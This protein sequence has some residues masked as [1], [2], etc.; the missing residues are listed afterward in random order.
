MHKRLTLIVTIVAAQGIALYAGP[1][2][3]AGKAKA[4]SKAESTQGEKRVL[5]ENP[6][7]LE[8]R[9]LYYGA[10]GKED[11]PAADAVFTFEKEDMNGTNPKYVVRDD[12]GTKWKV[13]LGD[14][15]KPEPVAA[16]LV[17]AVG[18]SADEDYFMPTIRVQNIPSDLKRGRK[19]IGPDG[20]MSNVRLK[21]ESKDFKKIGEWDWKTSPFAGTREL[22][23]LRVLM[24]VMNNWDLK[25]VNNAIMQSKGDAG[26][27]LVYIVSDLGA[28]FGSPRFDTGYAHDKGDLEA[29]RKSEFIK[30]AGA[31][32]V[33]FGS[34]GEPS[35]AIV[36][37][38][39]QYAKRRDL[40]WVG[41]HIPRADARWM[42]EQLGRLSAKQLEDAFRAGGYTQS[43]AD[44]YTTI[45]QDRIAQLKKL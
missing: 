22:N 24:S 37:N 40:V 17:W 32:D 12:K 7:D 15:A 41:Q 35:A 26:N 20:T 8:Q 10:K 2:A 31:S 4:D 5:W 14:E 16:R 43:Q 19:L 33:D 27:Q 23:G 21:L 45:L 25:S 34:P 42:G 39:S 13:K 38:P 28:S 44:Q 30:K 1:A 29:Y 18:Y 6:T 11:M 3:K 36:F 9:D